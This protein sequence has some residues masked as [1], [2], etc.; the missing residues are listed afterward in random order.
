MGKTYQQVH[1]Y[2]HDD[3]VNAK[4]VII[5]GA[6]GIPVDFDYELIAYDASNR[7]STITY[8]N[9]GPSG[10]TVALKTLT[11]VVAGNGAG[12]VESVYTV[13]YV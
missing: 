8:K 9:G 13:V 2:E 3:N 4:R 1:E 6:D 11:Y 5:I 7:V 12:E 10:S